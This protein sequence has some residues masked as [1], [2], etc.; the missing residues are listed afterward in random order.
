MGRILPFY[1]TGGVVSGGGGGGGNTGVPLGPFNDWSELPASAAGGS[2]AFVADLGPSLSSGIAVYDTG[3]SE[4]K[5]QFGTFGTLAD[6]LTF[7]DPISSL[8]V[9]TVGTLLDDPESVRYQWDDTVPEWVRT[10]ETV[11]YAWDITDLTNIDPSGIGATQIGDYG[12]FTDPLTGAINVYR[13]AT[14]NIASGA[15]SGT[16]TRWIPEDV[17]GRANL[18]VVAYC[19]GDEAMPGYGSSL[20]GY[21]YERTGAATIGTVSGYMRLDAPTP[22][23]GNQFAYMTGPSIIGSKR[24]YVVSDVRGVTTGTVG[25]AGFFNSSLVP[26]S[27][28]TLAEQ[29]AYGST[30][31]PIFWDGFA[32]APASTSVRNGTGNTLSASDP[33]IIEGWSAGTLITDMMVTRVNGQV[34]CSLVRNF[35]AATTATDFVVFIFA[36]GNAGGASSG[37]FEIRN[38]YVMTY[39]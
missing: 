33:W 15:G 35:D 18:E 3:D 8:A 34:Y 28:W 22:G 14:I 27:Q 32:W 11:P 21:T 13:L 7:T 9:A 19:V 20:R 6:L 36:G 30:M 39:D 25:Q 17:Y 37:R 16:V 38:H 23:S 2:I 1:R 29:R 12:T 31:R 5:L 10:P 4:W 26:Q 24:F